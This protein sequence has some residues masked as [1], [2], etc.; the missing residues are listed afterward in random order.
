MAKYLS[1]YLNSKN[2]VVE[3]DDGVLDT[4][5]EAIKKAGFLI[6]EWTY[7]YTLEITKNGAKRL[8]LHG[9]VLG[10]YIENYMG[11]FEA[12]DYDD[13]GILPRSVE[14]RVLDLPPID[15]AHEALGDLV[16]ALSPEAW[17]SLPEYLQKQVMTALYP[18]GYGAHIAAKSKALMNEVRCA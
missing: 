11:G 14:D 9:D 18:Q 17:E 6:T 13:T 4:K 3:D 15:V 2:E 7:L 10:S 1:F 12:Q 5:E 8:A 16:N